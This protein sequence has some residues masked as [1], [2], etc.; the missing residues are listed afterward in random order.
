MKWISLVVLFLFLGC[1]ER[2]EYKNNQL[3]IEGQPG[4]RPVQFVEIEGC[5]YILLG[6]R[7]ITHKGNCKR[8]RE[9]LKKLVGR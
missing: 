8:C 9:E 1:A 7:N 5:E 6:D 4:V 3:A 2:T